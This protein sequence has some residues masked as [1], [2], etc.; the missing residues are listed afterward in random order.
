MEILTNPQ[1]KGPSR[2]WIR[3]GKKRPRLAAKSARGLRRSSGEENEEKGKEILEK[4]A[5]RKGYELSDL[6]QS[7]W[8]QPLYKRFSVNSLGDMF[9]AV[10]YGGLTPNQ[11]SAAPDRGV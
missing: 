3:H 11:I 8:L 5:K 10:G 6:L 9:A 4:E 7:E 1:S 2:D